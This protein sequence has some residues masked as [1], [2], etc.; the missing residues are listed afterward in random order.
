MTDP[1]G[2]HTDMSDSVAGVVLA[3]GAAR[4]LQPISAVVP[5]PLCPVGNRSLLDRAIGRLRGVCADVAVNVHHHAEAIIDAV[6]DQGVHVSH[7]LPEALGTAGAIGALRGWIGARGVAVVNADTFCVGDMAVLARGWDQS[8]VR[9]WVPGGGP[10]GPRS[11]VVGC[12]LP[13]EAVSVLD[14]TPSGLYELVWRDWNAAGRVEVIAFEG[15]FVDCGTPRRLLEANMLTLENTA[16]VAA[17]AVVRGCVE[18]SVVGAGARI[19]GSVVGSVVFPGAV[20]HAHE[21]LDRAI[22][23]GGGG[24]PLTVM[25]R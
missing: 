18:A 22:R 14:A 21:R 7:E 24:R 13:N 1:L 16:A 3:A 2:C 19:E 9:L 5:K 23:Y 10:F 17:D 4:R 8:T 11:P 12:L 15:P 6:A 25:V 20:V